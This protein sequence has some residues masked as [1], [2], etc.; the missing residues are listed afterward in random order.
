MSGNLP[1][2]WKFSGWDLS[3]WELSWVGVFSVRVILGGNF[4]GGSYPEWELSWVGIFFGRSFPGENCLVGIIWVT[5]FQVGL[6]ILSFLHRW[7]YCWKCEFDTDVKIE[8]YYQHDGEQLGF[9]KKVHIKRQNVLYITRNEEFQFI[10]QK[11]CSG[12]RQMPYSTWRKL[13]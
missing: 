10:W 8:N 4:L 2:Y 7:D 12:G 1:R 11:L 13:T 5:I 6:F 9:Y 3:K